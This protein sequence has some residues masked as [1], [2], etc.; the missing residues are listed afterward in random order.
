MCKHIHYI[1]LERT[2]KNSL[3]PVGNLSEPL[4]EQTELTIEE[5][6]GDFTE[7]QQA[8][9]PPR[10]DEPDYEKEVFELISHVVRL[11]QS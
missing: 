9:L 7:I 10:T 6:S 1:G 3:E 11:L 5:M 2:K 4:L 8:L